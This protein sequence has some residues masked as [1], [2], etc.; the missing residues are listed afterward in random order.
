VE[1]ERAA[2]FI[3]GYLV[4]VSRICLNVFSAK[5]HPQCRRKVII[6]GFPLGFGSCNLDVLGA[7]EPTSGTSEVGTAVGFIQDF[8]SCWKVIVIAVAKND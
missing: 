2:K 3:E 8:N 5:G 6:V 7:F 4:A 1:W